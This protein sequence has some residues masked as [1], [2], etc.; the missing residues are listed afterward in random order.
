M[1][2]FSMII[3]RDPGSALNANQHR[4]DTERLKY[5][6]K[7]IVLSTPEYVAGLQFDTVILVDVNRSQVP[8]GKNS[9]FHLRRFLSELYLGMS[10]AQQEL[11]LVSSKD[12][13]GLPVMLEKAKEM[14]VIIP[15]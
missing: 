11:F 15:A 10:R 2:Q 14:G 12:E 3:F 1:G 6:G 7:R 13:G 4:D 9:S 5:L 8:E